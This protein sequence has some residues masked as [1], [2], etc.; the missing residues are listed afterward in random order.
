MRKKKTKRMVSLE[1]QFY[2]AFNFPGYLK[3]R[4]GIV[5]LGLF[6]FFLYDTCEISEQQTS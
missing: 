1:V 4:V 3:I 5:Q 6:S 2:L